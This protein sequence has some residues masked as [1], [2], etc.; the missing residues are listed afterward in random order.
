MPGT[1]S[2]SGRC[3]VLYHALNSCTCWASISTSYMKI[4][5]PFWAMCPS[6]LY[7]VAAIVLPRLVGTRSS[8]LEPRRDTRHPLGSH[9]STRRHT[10]HHGEAMPMAFSPARHALSRQGRGRPAQAV[11]GLARTANACR[12]GVHGGEQSVL[13]PVG[14]SVG[15]RGVLR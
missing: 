6:P 15:E 3:S 9:L 10:K 1:D 11:S 8:R 12:A 14:N 2:N 13:V 7:N 5:R 4:P